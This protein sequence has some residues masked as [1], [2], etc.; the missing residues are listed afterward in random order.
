MVDYSAVESLL[1]IRKV[2][3]CSQPPE[4]LGVE[5]RLGCMKRPKNPKAL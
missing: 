2:I 3:V 5:L 4:G 1:T